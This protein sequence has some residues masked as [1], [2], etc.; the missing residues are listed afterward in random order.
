VDLLKDT[1]KL[2]PGMSAEVRVELAVSAPAPW[3]KVSGHIIGVTAEGGRAASVAMTGPV[4]LFVAVQPDGTFEFPQVMPGSYRIDVFPKPDSLDGA[5]IVGDLVVG[6]TDLANIDIPSSL[7][8]FTVSGRAPGEAELRQRGA[9]GNGDQIQAFLVDQSRSRPRVAGPAATPQPGFRVRTTGAG[10]SSR[11]GPDGAFQ[12]KNVFPGEYRL[13]FSV[14]R[15]GSD[16]IGVNAS[17]GTPVTVVDKDIDGL[18][19]PVDLSG[20]FE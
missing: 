6:A 16:S 3:K 7:V 11:L 19:V 1:L 18:V 5:V 2:T 8:V 13:T 4:N 10:P 14:L 15:A 9:L 20:G 17:S 12:F